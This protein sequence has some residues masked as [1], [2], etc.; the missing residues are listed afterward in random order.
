MTKF[1]CNGDTEKTNALGPT[2]IGAQ[3]GPYSGGYMQH[4]PLSHN[5]YPPNNRGHMDG[6]TQD[7]KKWDSLSLDRL[8]QPRI[9]QSVANI[10]I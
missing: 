10:V 1:L 7:V 6:G 4:T 5:T 9:L 8:S 2:H 3:T